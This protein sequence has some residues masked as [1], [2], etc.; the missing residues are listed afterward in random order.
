MALKIL[1]AFVGS[2][3]KEAAVGDPNTKKMS[4]A[5]LYSDVEHTGY[6]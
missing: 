1:V 3:F 2:N 6:N 4:Q 5:M